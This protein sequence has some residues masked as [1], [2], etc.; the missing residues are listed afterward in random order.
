MTRLAFG[1]TIGV[2]LR[3]LGVSSRLSPKS[4]NDFLTARLSP[5]RVEGAGHVG[6][7]VGVGAEVVALAWI[8]AAGR[9][10]ERRPS[11]YSSEEANTG[12][13]M[14]NVIARETTRRHER[15]AVSI[16]S[17]KYGANSR[18]TLLRRSRTRRRCGSGTLHG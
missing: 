8:R 6:A 13:G 2:S 7:L 16:A 17:L 18:D 9:R 5:Q 12:T 4:R 3:E 14:P 10:G 15:S 1:P 11:K